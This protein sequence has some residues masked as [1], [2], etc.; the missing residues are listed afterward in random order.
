MKK[1][2]IRI[3][4]LL[5]MFLIACAAA[6]GAYYYFK[7]GPAPT[8][9]PATDGRDAQTRGRGLD[10]KEPSL[11]LQ[12]EVNGVLKANKAQVKETKHL[13]KSAGG[14]QNTKIDW[15]ERSQLVTI[16]ASASIEEIKD[17]LNKRLKSKSGAVA[18]QEQDKWEGQNVERIDIALITDDGDISELIVDRIYFAPPAKAKKAGH[19]RLAVIVDD[20]GYD[21]DI[22]RK[23]TG[24]KQKLSFAVI[25]Y[26]NFSAEAL[27][28]IKKSGKEALLHLPMEPLDRSQQ[29]EKITIAVNMSDD[30][31]KQI[32]RKAIEQLP[33]I[34]GV[35]NHQG[36]RATADER[37]MRAVLSVIKEKRLFFVD[38]FTQ[39]KTLAYKVAGQMGVRTAIN[40]AFM[41]G[42]ADVGYIKGRLRQAGEQA[43]KEG[44]YI[45]ICHA[46]PQTAIALS[47]TLNELEAIGV[48]FVFVSSL[49]SR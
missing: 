23:I 10:Y 35:N 24:L 5:S 33:G 3:A 40:R 37:I 48:E 4:R 31:A 22:V 8:A 7:T 34:V 36:S 27:A 26:R 6:V 32:T 12:A 45:A 29:S 25:P 30:E 17:D 19:G 14:K 16:D 11:A 39:P 47:E 49:V 42:E 1:R 41:D 2:K 20:C 21:A 38:S 15:L 18:R 28:I 43:L 44:S 9:P 46:R 13:E